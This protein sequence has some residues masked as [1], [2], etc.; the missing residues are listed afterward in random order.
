MAARTVSDGTMVRLVEGGRTMSAGR[1]WQDIKDEAHRRFPQLADADRQAR[2]RA[3]LDAQVAGHHLK[4]LREAM[5]L[6]QR[7]ELPQGS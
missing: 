5:G 4:E 6:T 3:E 1:S 2:A 7:S